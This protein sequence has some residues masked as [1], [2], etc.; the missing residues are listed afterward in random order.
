MRGAFG[1]GRGR[2]LTQGPEPRR[3]VYMVICLPETRGLS[4]R[5]ITYKVT[6]PSWVHLG[7]D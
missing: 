1:E 7:K 5:E 6:R 4:R 2:M 3:R